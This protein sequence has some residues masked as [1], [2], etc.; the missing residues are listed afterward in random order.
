LKE[1]KSITESKFEESLNTL[2]ELN[3]KKV[4]KIFSKV[5]SSSSES[6]DSSIDF[7]E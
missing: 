2:K 1:S 3:K 4:S 5:L 6:T 7:S